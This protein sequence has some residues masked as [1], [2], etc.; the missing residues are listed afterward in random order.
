MSRETTKQ[1]H[2]PNLLNLHKHKAFQLVQTVQEPDVPSLYAYAY[3]YQSYVAYGICK[4]ANLPREGERTH[5]VRSVF[6][7]AGLKN[8]SGG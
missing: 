8:S 5:T 2:E 1:T 7:S 6:A 4:P 3:A